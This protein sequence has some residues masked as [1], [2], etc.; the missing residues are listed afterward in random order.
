[1]QESKE[2]AIRFGVDLGGTKTELIALDGRG[3]VV[4][5]NRIATARDSYKGTL[6]GIV[7]LVREAETDLA[8]TGSLGIGIPGTLSRQTGLVKNANS[9]WLIGQPLQQDLEDMLQRPVRVANDA[10]CF[11]VSESVDGAGAGYDSVFAVILGTGVGAGCVVYQRLLPSS[12]GLAGE[13]GHNPLPWI[14]ERERL[15]VGDCYCG[16][17]GC[18]EQFLSG[19][20]LAR[21]YRQALIQAGRSE[22][23]TTQGLANALTSDA[24]ALAVFEQYI[25]YLVK[26]LAHVINLIDPEIIVLGGGISNIEALYPKLNERLA[27]AVFGRECVTQVVRNSHGDSSGVRGAA[28]LWR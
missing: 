13:W 24:L 11:A 27:D 2:P 22:P 16:R 23:A 15:N 17:K 12:N 18:I 1:V 6:K 8:T 7:S 14:S 3:E 20:A 4:W 19:P 5:C 26:G 9:T 28:W 25:D 10:D 21:Q